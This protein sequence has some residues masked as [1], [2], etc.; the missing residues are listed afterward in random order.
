MV[1]ND[2]YQLSL[3][4]IP[5]CYVSLSYIFSGEVCTRTVS[6][7]I[8]ISMNVCTKTLDALQVSLCVNCKWYDLFTIYL[9]FSYDKRVPYFL[10]SGSSGRGCWKL[11]CLVNRKS[12]IHQPLP[13]I[14]CF[15]VA[16]KVNKKNNT[17]L[18]IREAWRSVILLTVDDW[19]FDWELLCKES[20]LWVLTLFSQLLFVFR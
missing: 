15:N 14:D 5:S 8:G 2:C 17:M 12:N 3:E 11:C 4:K 10:W 20:A 18:Y 19:H 16:M 1:R 6:E 7:D 9:R 13:Q